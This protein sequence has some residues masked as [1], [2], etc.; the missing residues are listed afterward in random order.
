MTELQLT[1]TNHPSP[2]CSAQYDA[3][4]GIDEKKEQLL[5]ELTLIL[6]RSG[7]D[8]WVKRHHGVTPW[9]TDAGLPR[10]HLIILSGDVGC[11]KTALASSV[12]S[13]L[14]KK[15]DR[16]VLA[17]ETPSN[18]RGGG[19]VGEI[20]ARIT[21]TFDKARAQIA[22]YPGVLVIDEADD[23]A[24]SRSQMQAH[25]E[26]R[27]GLNVLIKQIDLLERSRAQLAVILITN[28]VSVLD[29]AVSRR[30][31]LHLVFERPGD[32]SRRQAFERLLQG[33]E[34]GS[35]Q[36]DD[37]VMKSRRVPVPYTYSDL[38]RRVARTA[39]LSAWRKNERLSI[40][41][42]GAALDRVEPSP[43]M[44]E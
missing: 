13:P 36:L 39:I 7:F 17:L 28:R 9:V 29:P 18:I 35:R 42:F 4:V 1:V 26:D 20:S 37:L 8:D 34:Y 33:L 38:M 2:E 5:D 32:D 23:L 41:H 30:T 21:E 11:G 16:K 43:A 44:G 27:A 19:R 25:H 22:R 14:A 3:L 12:C 6:D 24:T 40:V 10:S 15:L 31:G